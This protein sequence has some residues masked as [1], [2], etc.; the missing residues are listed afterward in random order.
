MPDEGEGR[1]I[2]LKK[3][4][5]KRLSSPIFAS[6]WRRTNFHVMR[7]GTN[8]VSFFEFSP[9]APENAAI[10]IGAQIDHCGERK[11]SSSKVPATCQAEDCH[12]A[13]LRHF[14]NNINKPNSIDV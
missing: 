2:A 11:Q 13:V 1:A 12:W 3:R 6:C 4:L 8:L 9:L 5:I 7:D 14:V 10:M